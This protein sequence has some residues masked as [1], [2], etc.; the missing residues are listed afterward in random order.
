MKVIEFKRRVKRIVLSG[1][2]N[3]VSFTAFLFYHLVTAL[4][5]PFAVSEN[6]ELRLCL[7]HLIFFRLESCESKYESED[8]SH[9][10]N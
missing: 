1:S 6:H 8:L 2:V 10:W 7:E 3:A 9:Y 4:S 5:H